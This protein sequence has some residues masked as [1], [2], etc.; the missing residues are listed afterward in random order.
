MNFFERKPKSV[1][2]PEVL[3]AKDHETLEEMFGKDTAEEMRR[4]AK[5]FDQ[6]TR[7]WSED[8]DA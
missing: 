2:D 1:P 5:K 7:D 3:V 4:D 8:K 6:R